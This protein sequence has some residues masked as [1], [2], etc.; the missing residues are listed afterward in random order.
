V[1]SMTGNPPQMAVSGTPP[2]GALVMS[3]FYTSLWLT[4]RDSF[5]PDNP[6]TK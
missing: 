3:M 6:P 1:A 4:F 5:T 2:L